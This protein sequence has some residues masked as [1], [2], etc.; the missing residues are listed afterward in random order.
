M[1]QQIDIFKKN[2][3]FLLLPRVQFSIDILPQRDGSTGLYCLVDGVLE[4]DLFLE[5]GLDGHAFLE[6]D[7]KLVDMVACY[8]LVLWKVGLQDHSNSRWFVDDSWHR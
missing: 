5:N 4:G 8:I 3:N 1:R 7:D 2:K 6:Y